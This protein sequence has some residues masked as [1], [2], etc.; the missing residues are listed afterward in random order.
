MSKPLVVVVGATGSQGGSVADVLLASGRYSV[1][2]LTRKPDSPV[3][4]A[5]KAKGAEVVGADISKKE[6]LLKAFHGAYAVFAVTSYWETGLE[7]ELDQGKK[8]ADA[9]K[10][11]NVSHYIYS[12]LVDTRAISGGK[13]EVPH[14]WGKASI[15]EHIFASGLVATSVQIACYY[16]NWAGWFIPKWNE[17]DQV[18]EFTIPITG[19]FAVG[20]VGDLGPVVLS[21]LDNKEKYA[22]KTVAVA[23]D[24]IAGDEVAAAFTRQWGKPVRCNYVPEK[25]F[26]SFGFPGAAELADMF[27][28]FEDYGYFGEKVNGTD[29]WEGKKIYPNMLTFEEWLKIKGPKSPSS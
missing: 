27:G 11:Q 9:A 14:F 15:D 25:V 29:I 8:M 19:K 4:L 13:R 16:E 5:L 23:G 3:A 17:K 28:F 20:S 7:V 2:A 21:I 1:R 22:G 18:Y 26:A 24:L 12:S 10:E 6:D